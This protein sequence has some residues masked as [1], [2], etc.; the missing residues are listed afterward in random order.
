MPE[1][2]TGTLLEGRTAEMSFEVPGIP[3]PKPRMTRRDKW[4]MKRPRTAK[5]L[6][7]AGALKRYWSWVEAVRMCFLGTSRGRM[8]FALCRMGFKFF[9]A[10]HPVLDLDNLI[11]GVKDAIKGAAFEDDNALV[12]RGYYDDPEVVFL[13]DD[14]KE[15]DVISRGPRAGMR[16]PDCGDVDR[17]KLPRSVIKIKGVLAG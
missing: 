16:K 10:G 11:K 5:D 14:C 13:C 1:A 15:R 6:A 2:T 3:I 8:R 17:C 9:V 7:R 4:I 12:V